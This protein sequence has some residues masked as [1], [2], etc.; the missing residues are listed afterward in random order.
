LLRL[1]LRRSGFRSWLRRR[2]AF[3]LLF[4]FGRRLLRQDHA[5][6]ILWRTDRGPRA[7]GRQDGGGKQQAFQ[8]RHGFPFL[9]FRFDE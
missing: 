4:R 1:P 5:R 9:G 2:L 7:G 8:R 6:F 3:G